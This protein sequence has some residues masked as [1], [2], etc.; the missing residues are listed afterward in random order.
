ML[1]PAGWAT[2]HRG[3]WGA[4]RASTS[5]WPCDP[6][7]VLRLLPAQ[8]RGWG[9]RLPP[10]ARGAF[11]GSRREC[12]Q[13]E[14]PE[15]SPLQ[16]P[17]LSP[18]RFSCHTHMRAHTV[19]A[20]CAHPHTCLHTHCVLLNAAGSVPLLGL[21][22]GPLSRTTVP[23][24]SPESF[25]PTLTAG[26]WACWGWRPCHLDPASRRQARGTVRTG[27]REVPAC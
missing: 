24:L 27:C 2:P 1:Q 26:Q 4:L 18:R 17:P 11:L 21:C 10:C 19:P 12:P 7:R 5:E 9:L 3:S 22:R 20:P 13:Q 16:P 8:R 6:E 25:L 15:P 23:R 14:R